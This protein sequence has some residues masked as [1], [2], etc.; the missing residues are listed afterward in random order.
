[1]NA[2]WHSPGHNFVYS[3]TKSPNRTGAF[4]KNYQLAG[5]RLQFLKQIPK[6]R[7]PIDT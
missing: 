7:I 2:V 3:Q 4:Q 5:V 1:M 6:N